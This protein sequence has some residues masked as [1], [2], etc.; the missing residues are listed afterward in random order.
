MPMTAAKERVFVWEGKDKSGKLLRGEMKAV[1]EAL[2]QAQLRRQGIFVLKVQARRFSRQGAVKPQDLAVFTRQ[3]ATMIRAGVPLLQSIDIIAKSS[4]SLGLSRILAEVRGD[5]ATGTDLSTALRRHTELFNPLYC[6]LVAVG[7]ASGM[8]EQTLDRLAV[9]EEKSLALRNQIRSALM[10]PTGVMVVA[11]LVLVVIL[12]FVVPTFKEV[13]ASFGAELPAMTRAV[14]GLSEVLQS[15]W[16]VVLLG[17]VALGLGLREAWRRSDTFKD[18]CDA[19]VLRLPVVGE[20]I[21]KAVVARWTRTLCTLYGAGVPLVDALGHLAS[22]SGNR[23]YDRATAAIQRD[24]STGQRL[25]LAMDTTGL[26]PP[27]VL[28]MASIGEESG[29]LDHMLNKAADFFE[30]EVDEKV[31]G[32]SSLLEP[33]IITVLGVLIG[34]IVVAMYLPIFQLGAIA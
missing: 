30:D 24:V 22:S 19:A 28:Q 3:L 7:E 16:W 20:L 12:V 23:G 21:R 13:F 1:G 4:T 27:M 6:N 34:G 5:V 9:Y 26:F 31:K 29:A 33:L 17:A 10:Y 25:T 14:I 11:S 2:V 8:L 18:R 32:L 15:W